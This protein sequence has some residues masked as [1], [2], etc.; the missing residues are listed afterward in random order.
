MIKPNDD[1]TVTYANGPSQT[2][3]L[4]K[5]IQN[6]IGL[7]VMMHVACGNLTK[8]S[9]KS[10]LDAAKKSGITNILAIRG[11]DTDTN[12]KGGDFEY[13]IDFVKFVRK[14]YGNSF[15]IA[16]A[17]FPEGY[18]ESKN[19]DSDLK[20]LKAKIDA[21]ADMIVTQLF[22][23]P[24][25]C[26]EYV[27][28]CREIGIKC[29]IVPGIMPIQSYRTLVRMTSYCHV[30]LPEQV[31]KDLEP[32]KDDD[33]E[34]KKYGIR[35]GSQMVKTLLQSDLNIRGVHFYTLNLARSVMKICQASGLDRLKTVRQL[36]WA[37]CSSSKRK[38]EGVRPIFWANRPQS[39]V[40][41]TQSWDEFPNGRWGDCRSPAW[42]DSDGGHFGTRR[43][44]ITKRRA[45]WGDRLVDI[46]DVC[47]VFARYIL[48]EIDFTPWCEGV[49]HHE[50][51]TIQKAILEMNC[52]GCLTINSQPRANGLSS[53]HEIYGWGGRGGVVYQKA[54]VEFFCS[55]ETLA[56]LMQRIDSKHPSLTYHAVDVTGNSYTNNKGGVT[57]VT[58]GVWPNQEIKQPTVVDPAAFLV[59]KQ[60][61]FKL[62]LDRWASLYD[63]DSES[64]ELIHR[65]HDNYFLVNLVDNDF[66][67]GDLFSVFDDLK[68]SVD[69]KMSEVESKVIE[70]KVVDAVSS[71]D[72]KKS[73]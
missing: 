53:D 57:A 52:K 68:F 63:E 67:A 6:L 10:L 34:V 17:G 42:G 9:A 1:A 15:G 21:G 25:T 73:N 28:K 46:A 11:D 8:S 60:E 43:P 51:E 70:A 30:T 27:R 44:S 40:A 18:P 54:Y 2:L 19:A 4:S 36:P 26:L 47:R 71:D 50:T 31:R 29:P 33:A 56:L 55:P 23:D 20:F 39:Y 49:L 7:D 22:F 12:A 69:A 62:W 37:S 58:W 14:E 13:T 45:A 48:G 35:Y 5:N 38:E 24:Q 66:V 64:Y 41:R 61:A 16:V 65:I 72:V 3:E 59:W 32:I